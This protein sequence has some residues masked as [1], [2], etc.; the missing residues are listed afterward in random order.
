[1]AAKNIAGIQKQEPGWP[2]ASSPGRSWAG[3]R[4]LHAQV[5]LGPV[6]GLVGG[7][8]RIDALQAAAACHVLDLAGSQLALHIRL[9]ARAR[10]ASL[11]G[12][13]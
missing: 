6:A 2:L 4:Q 1:M 13:I 3:A 8:E 11:C 7:Q 5:D 9:H 12:G 10:A